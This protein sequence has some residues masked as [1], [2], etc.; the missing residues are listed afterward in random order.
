MVGA[1]NFL[2]HINNSES[3]NKRNHDRDGVWISNHKDFKTFLLSFLLK[4]SFDREEVSNTPDIYSP[5]SKH[6]QAHQKFFAVR[7]I[8]DSLKASRCLEMWSN[9]VFCV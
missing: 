6:L 1:L 4:F 5:I 3:A 9:I 2:K 7:R 8:L